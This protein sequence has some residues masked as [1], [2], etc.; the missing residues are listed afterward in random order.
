MNASEIQRYTRTAIALHWLMAILVFILFG[1]GWTMTDLPRG[2]D[3][4]FNF[5]LHK[6]IG[7]T[8]FL[9]LICR[10][11]WRLMHPPPPMPEEIGAGR[12][13]LARSAHLMFYVLLLMQPVI[14]YLSSSF[15]GYRT[16]YFGIPLPHWGWENRALNEFLTEIHVIGSVAIATL[17]VLHVLGAM[18]HLL[19]SG[20]H[21]FRRILPW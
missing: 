21:V 4:T 19:S 17:I 11:A 13:M 14:G 15:S 8:V 18:S 16:K 12:I 1:L 7:L 9:L 10:A 6:S 2:P 20:D 5:A 3:R